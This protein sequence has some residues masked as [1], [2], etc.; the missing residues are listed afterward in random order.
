M[1][2][3][4]TTRQPRTVGRR[5]ILSATPPRK[6]EPIAMPISSI[7]ST[8][9]S[10]AR[11][12]PHSRMMPGEAKLIDRT[13]KPSSALSRTVRPTT[14]I[15]SRLMGELATISLGSTLIGGKGYH[16]PAG[17]PRLFRLLRLLLQDRIRD[18]AGTHVVLG[19]PVD[20][21]EFN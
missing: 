15:C 5:P 16:C 7:D 1:P 9:P 3:A 8:M 20:A 13:S 21:D 2:P 11:L 17:S 19:A 12:M 4:I 14:A 10:A 6:M 18:A